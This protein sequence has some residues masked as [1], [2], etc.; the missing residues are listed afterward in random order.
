M[1]QVREKKSRIAHSRQVSMFELIEP[2]KI[3]K[4]CCPIS[5]MRKLRLAL[6]TALPNKSSG[7]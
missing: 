4:P 6:V 3:R 2:Y 1:F 5:Q 7:E